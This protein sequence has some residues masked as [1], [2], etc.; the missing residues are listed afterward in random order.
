MNLLT[1]LITVIYYAL[2]AFISV[3]II[4]NLVKTRDW[5][6]EIVYVIILLPFLLRLFLL[7]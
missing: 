7:K 4:Y 3:L 2:V 5:K 1:T 6:K